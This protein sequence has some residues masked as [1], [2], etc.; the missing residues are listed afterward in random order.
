M[1]RVQVASDNFNR[2][3]GTLG[4]NWDDMHAG[5]SQSVI[6]TNQVRG[7]SG[8]DE[9]ARWNGTGTFTSDQ[10]SETEIQSLSFLNDNYRTGVIVA[11]TGHDGTRTYYY[12]AVSYDGG[13]PDY[14]TRITK[15]VNGTDTDLVTG[16]KNWAN[17]DRLGLEV[18][19]D[20]SGGVNLVVTNGGAAVSGMSYHDTSSALTGGK[21]GIYEL[22][23]A[24]RADNWT[25]GNIVSFIAVA[26]NATA[27]ASAT[28][29]LTTQIRTAAAAADVASAS[30]ALTTAIRLAAA[31]I[32]NV[33]ATGAI[34]TGNPIAANASDVA[35]S[36]GVLNNGAV[37][38]AA[39]ADVVTSTA[40]LSTAIRLGAAA[41]A[42]ASASAA[43]VDW[44]TVTLAGSLYTGIG[45]ALDPNF[46][47]DSVPTLGTTIYYD[48]THITIFPNGEVA[49][50]TNSCFAVCQFFDGANWALGLIVIT[51]F[52]VAYANNVAAAV[53][54]LT[55]A[56]QLA[57][58]AQALVT[59]TA[60]LGTGA[61][62]FANAT[63]V[64]SGAANLT[65]PKP[66]A[67][68]AN[69][70]ATAVG[71]LTAQILLA[72]SALSQSTATAQLANPNALLAAATAV[73]SMTALIT[74]GI[75]LAGTAFGSASSSGAISTGVQLSGAAA[76]VVSAAGQLSTQIRVA[77]SASD[78]SGAS[79]N[80]TVTI[81][82]V[83]AA[84]DAASALAT[85]STGINLSAN[86][87]SV[88]GALAEL[89]GAI[90]LF[91]AARSQATAT[92]TLT[93]IA[94][95]PLIGVYTINPDYIVTKPRSYGFGGPRRTPKFRS[96]AA[97][98]SVVLTFDF[99]GLLPAGQTFVGPI[100]LAIDAT[101]G[102]D[103]SAREVIY[104]YPAYDIT[105]RKI[106]QPIRGGL[107]RRDY[108]I[109][110]T[111]SNGTHLYTLSGL[112]PVRG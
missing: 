45:G 47:V 100:T 9:P 12:A 92:A 20:G 18:T 96:K 42:N 99:A 50:D 51:P 95:T 53:G 81:P 11:G 112:L 87:V 106:V 74:T 83:A 64:A 10:Y 104:G 49:S 88:S 43:L 66:I 86:A 25:G 65:N 61:G 54:Q 34:S 16:R 33:T 19:G 46:W 31:A 84:I 24:V 48:P 3:D 27:V 89:F 6:D 107:H 94:E 63:D 15:C 73:D 70:V 108:F 7:N 22:A 40:G 2:A 13:G 36:T 44:A 59:A 69:D 93:D 101:S 5:F 72:S 23:N 91:A 110:V 35:T 26:G 75:P 79:G 71:N 77:A 30:A 14:L 57:A 32:V 17:G 102:V 38:Q 105:R 41:S 1:A 8:V 85:I 29:D 111:A 76:N 90:A 82:L 28:G 52:M 55:T 67:A 68:I 62:L 4:T 21:P 98:D 58:A 80:L 39:I 56:I 78:T 97:A 37:L 60:A 103:A 109:T